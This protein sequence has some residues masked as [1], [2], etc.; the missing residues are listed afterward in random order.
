[1]T[2]PFAFI[3]NTPLKLPRTDEA[4]YRQIGVK[5]WGATGI[6]WCL[7]VMRCLVWQIVWSGGSAITI[8]I[9]TIH[10]TGVAR[11]RKR[12]VW[13]P[14]HNRRVHRRPSP[15]AGRAGL[16]L[17]ADRGEPVESRVQL[18]A[19]RDAVNAAADRRLH[20]RHRHCGVQTPPRSWW[21][22]RQRALHNG[23]NPADFNFEAHRIDGVVRFGQSG[24]GIGNGGSRRIDD[25]VEFDFPTLATC[26]R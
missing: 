3:P 10:V 22:G 18:P 25:E 13:V 20:G 2:M 4:A 23:Q 1:M 8:S 21:R 12:C 11:Y 6:A 9:P 26:W 17:G 24:P 16:H 15:S 19:G 7:L 5:R 14:K